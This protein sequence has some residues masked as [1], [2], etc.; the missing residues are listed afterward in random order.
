MADKENLH[1]SMDG[2]WS[3]QLTDIQQLDSEQP[4]LPQGHFLSVAG[5]MLK[6]HCWAF[7]R[8][9]VQVNKTNK[10]RKLEIISGRIQM[11]QRQVRRE[12]LIKIIQTVSIFEFG[13]G[14]LKVFI[15][16]HSRN[17]NS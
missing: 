16:N 4:S 15:Q 9:F 6:P 11:S 10:P 17:N 8:D 14:A 7:S 12:L 2:W 3:V 1:G 5:L 13:F